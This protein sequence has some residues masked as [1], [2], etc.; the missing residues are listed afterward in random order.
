MMFRI[1]SILL[2]LSYALIG[3]ARNY[4]YAPLG[5]WGLESTVIHAKAMRNDSSLNKVQNASKKTKPKDPVE[6]EVEDDL[7]RAEKAFFHAVEKVE[8]K[9]VSAVEKVEE[10]VVHAIDDEVESLFPHHQTKD[11]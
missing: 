5:P 8:E 3:E 9:V 1:A 10:T 11:E 2:A 7:E 6:A 4:Y